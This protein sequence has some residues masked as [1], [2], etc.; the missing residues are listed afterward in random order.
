LVHSVVN[1]LTIILQFNQLTINRLKL[2]SFNRE[3]TSVDQS[4]Y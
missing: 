4:F 2:F 3:S 1:R